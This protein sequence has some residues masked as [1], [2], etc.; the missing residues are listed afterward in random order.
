MSFSKQSL[1]RMIWFSIICVGLWSYVRYPNFFHAESLASFL[2]RY[3]EQA[4]WMYLFISLARGLFLIPSTPF[5]LAGVLLFPH[6]VFWVFVIS[7]CGVLFG[8]TIVYFFSERLGFGESLRKNHPRLYQTMQ[9]K[10]KRIGFPIVMLWS[11][12]PLV[13]TDLIC[14]V[15]GTIRMPYHTFLLALLIGECV[16]IWGYIYTGK[17]LLSFVFS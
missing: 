7:M 14:C 1:G 17:T 3:Q 16:L 4:L 11:F 15:A 5:V 13:P 2:S 12:F 8:S 9:T 6:N 10:M